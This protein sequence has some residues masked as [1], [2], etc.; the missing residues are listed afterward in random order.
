M[1][2]D[3]SALGREG[4]QWGAN[5]YGGFEAGGRET[6]EPPLPAREHLL[7]LADFHRETRVGVREHPGAAGL[8]EESVDRSHE[9]R[10]DRASRR[11]L[12]N[13]GEFRRERVAGRRLH[14]RAELPAEVFL[15]AVRQ[16]DARIRSGGD[17]RVLKSDHRARV[18]IEDPVDAR[19]PPLCVKEFHRPL[20]RQRVVDLMQGSRARMAWL[21]ANA[22]L[23]RGISTPKPLGIVEAEGRSYFVNEYIPDAVSL[24]DYVADFGRPRGKAAVRCWHAF[25][26]AVATFVRKL[27]THRL[28]HLDLAAKNILTREHDGGFEFFLIDLS[29]L[30]LG[31][32]P[33]ARFKIRNLGQLAQLHVSPSRTDKLRFFRRYVADHPE[34]DR[35]EI[36]L[37]IDAI[38]RARHERWLAHGG[39]EWL[40]ERGRR[41]KPI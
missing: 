19:F 22:C 12:G 27:H 41:G 30:R 14:R 4:S 32:A 31:R 36:L 40:E 29:D 3:A 7:I 38:G 39:R 28:R 33:S 23:V 13:T 20:V 18:T 15:E 2:R 8:S 26:D 17:S 16:H 24:N 10:Y 1:I 35:R 9:R 5:R 37:E 34:L 6:S 11:C 21:A 25:V